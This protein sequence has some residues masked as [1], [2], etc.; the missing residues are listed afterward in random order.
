[1]AQP[2]PS[3]K[4]FA[5]ADALVEALGVER[6]ELPVEEYDNGV[7]HVYVCLGSEDEV[8]ALG[9]NLR[10]IGLPDA[11]GTNCFAGSGKRWK[12]RMFGLGGIDE[13]P[14]TGSA[15]GP[16]AVHLARHGRIAFG[17]EIEIS[18]GAE[19]GRP[20]TLY[21]RAEGTVDALERIEVGGSAVVV[22]RG[23]LQ[24]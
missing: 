19:I 16:L 4:P 13:D 15:A 9:P 5:D 10:G 23:E 20:S 2:V 11:L 24:L 12:T 8:T 18:Q 21:A 17:E 22:A 1:M 7:Q 14:A 6:S 3:W